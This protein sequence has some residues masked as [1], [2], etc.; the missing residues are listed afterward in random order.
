LIRGAGDG[1]HITASCAEWACRLTEFLLS[2][3]AE[4]V[5]ANVATN[6]YESALQ[7]VTAFIRERGKVSMRDLSR[8]FRWLKPKERDAMIGALCDEK[9]VETRQ[10]PG[11]N[12]PTVMVYWVR[13]SENHS[14]VPPLSQPG[15]TAEPF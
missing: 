5:T 1:E 7:K 4:Q 2:R 14:A 12:S 11:N 6:E 15:G 8:K 10:I 9:A 13:D 3:T